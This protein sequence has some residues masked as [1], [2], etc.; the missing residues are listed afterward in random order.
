VRA[1][2]IFL[3]DDDHAFRE[4]VRE[5]LGGMHQV[6][7][8]VD[9]EGFRQGFRPFEF[10]LVILDMRLKSGREGF[11]LLR[12]IRAH[13]QF[14]P[15]IMVS[16]YG[17]TETTLDA[18][19]SGASMF[20]HKKE[21]TPELLARMV[22]AVLS[23]ARYQRRVIDLE[24]RLRVESPAEFIGMS[25]EI[26]AAAQGARR[27]AESPDA[28][29]LVNGELGTERELT[30]RIVHDLSRQRHDGPFVATS[31][32]EMREDA[33][34]DNLFGRHH[35]GTPRYRGVLEQ[36]NGG[37]LFLQGVEYLAPRLLQRLEA[38][39]HCRSID[40][41]PFAVALDVQLVVAKYEGR[42]SESAGL[43]LQKIAAGRR[44][45][46]VYLPPLRERKADIPLLAASFLQALRAGGHTTARTVSPAALRILEGHHWPGNVQELHN[47]VEFGAIQALVSGD[48][49]LRPEHLPSS[50]LN[51]SGSLEGGTSWDYR[52]H[53]A[54]S[55]VW[56]TNRGLEEKGL[57]NKKELAAALGYN[58][59]FSFV[60]RI[61]K[62]LQEFPELKRE[63]PR[64]AALFR[65]K[66]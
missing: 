40:V 37:V 58:D 21:F 27:A 52:A 50:L 2:K 65:T 57:K 54:R 66:A 3:V 23:Q 59:R 42:A 32:T 25:P 20:L 49:E 53:V 63:F 24:N 5:A 26:H 29:V 45:I 30:A 1:R 10:D 38:V 61:G 14:Q 28:P 56:L 64:V 22:E 31:L 17:D 44:W 47:A 48:E 6:K 19:E 8:A 7:E 62:S 51:P 43:F 35:N 33:A 39:L 9:E 13:D 15:V 12:E 34:E 18:I 60:R 4:R 11:D 16:A 46:E 55:E 36:A 41:G